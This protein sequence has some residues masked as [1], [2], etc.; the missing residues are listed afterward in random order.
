M[1]VFRGASRLFPHRW[2][3]VFVAPVFACAGY[4]WPT[5]ALLT[6]AVAVVAEG[7]FAIVRVLLLDRAPD[8]P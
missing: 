4:S 2:P 6:G 8:G 5:A 1:W 7:L 3:I